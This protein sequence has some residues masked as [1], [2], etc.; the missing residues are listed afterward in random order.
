MTTCF[1]YAHMTDEDIASLR[2]GLPV[3]CNL[4]HA[5]IWTQDGKV[6]IREAL[7]SRRSRATPRR[8]TREEP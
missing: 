2:E 6:Q 1:H 7:E 8:P 4:C 3:F 5:L